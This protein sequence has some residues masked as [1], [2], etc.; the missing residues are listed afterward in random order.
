MDG[1]L[2]TKHMTTLEQ[3]V[4]WIVVIQFRIVVK[5][6]SKTTLP[7]QV[8]KYVETHVEIKQRS[9]NSS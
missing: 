8:Q 6:N 9:L 7:T 3:L 2:Q 5:N 4:R 1:V